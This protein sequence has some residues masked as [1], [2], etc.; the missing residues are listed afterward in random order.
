M[1]AVIVVGNRLEDARRDALRGFALVIVREHAV[2]VG[3]AD[4]PEASVDVHRERV[5]GGNRE[6][7]LIAVE[8]ALPLKFA[9]ASDEV[10]RDRRLRICFGVRAD[11]WDSLAPT[12]EGLCRG[13]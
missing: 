10:R 3:V 9:K 11:W 1:D 2:H 4:W 6:D 13:V 8:Q 7:A 5:G 12:S